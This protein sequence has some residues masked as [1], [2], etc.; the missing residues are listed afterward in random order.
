M[1][2][3]C[4]SYII[5]DHGCAAVLDWMKVDKYF[6]MGGKQ[7]IRKMEPIILRKDRFCGQ[8]PLISLM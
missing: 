2:R 3:G 8:F 4:D 7:L 6:E 1:C 5:C